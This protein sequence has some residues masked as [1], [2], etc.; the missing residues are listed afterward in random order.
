MELSRKMRRKL[1]EPR[2]GPHIVKF[3]ESL[4]VNL[5]GKIVPNVF[6]RALLV[7]N[8]FSSS[9]VSNNSRDKADFFAKLRLVFAPLIS[10]YT[11]DSQGRPQQSTGMPASEAVGHEEKGK[12]TENNMLV[13]VQDPICLMPSANWLAMAAVAVTRISCLVDHRSALV[14]S[15][16]FARLRMHALLGVSRGNLPSAAHHFVESAFMREM[17]TK[18][19]QEEVR[20]LH[21]QLGASKAEAWRFKRKILN[22]HSQASK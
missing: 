20:A 5:D 16:A 7:A 9:K 10:A 11:S 3:V 17:E 1:P 15:R 6:Q 21:V 2:F 18:A 8:P 4:D 22:L 19:L 12:H 13:S 14:K